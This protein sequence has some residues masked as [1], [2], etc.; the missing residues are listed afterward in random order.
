MLL[1]SGSVTRRVSRNMPKNLYNV[2]CILKAQITATLRIC[3]RTP[4]TQ[5]RYT[6]EFLTLV[7]TQT[8][9]TER[10]YENNNEV[11]TMRKNY[12]YQV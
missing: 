2:I 11:N 8:K 6:E 7:H 9:S 5:Q 3:T 10:K 4:K 12:F 1:K